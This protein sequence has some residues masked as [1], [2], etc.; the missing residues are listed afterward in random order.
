MS[1]PRAK[2]GF[3]LRFSIEEQDEAGA[4]FDRRLIK[5]RLTKA[6]RTMKKSRILGYFYA[7]SYVT[8]CLLGNLVTGIIYFRHWNNYND[9]EFQL[10]TNLKTILDDDNHTSNENST[11]HGNISI[12][13]YMDIKMEFERPIW[14]NASILADYNEMIINHTTDKVR[15]YIRWLPINLYVCYAMNIF[16]NSMLSS[17]I[18]ILNLFATKKLKTTKTLSTTLNM[19]WKASLY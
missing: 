19:H 15:K 8:L 3:K 6:F 10:L 11:L 13:D 16:E 17:R 4:W 7:I 12:I 18:S 9:D 2:N 5:R 14:T 1:A